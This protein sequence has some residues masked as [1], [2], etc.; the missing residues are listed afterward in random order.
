MSSI[1][2]TPSNYVKFALPKGRFMSST[3][4]LLQNVGLGFKD[5]FDKSRQYRLRSELSPY[6]SAKVFQ[7]KDI[8]VQVAIGNYDL[9][10][11]GLDWIEELT[12]RYP[13]SALIKI[14]NL[15]YGKGSIYLSASYQTGVFESDDLQ[16]KQYS[17][18][19]VSEYPNLAQAFALDRRL[20]KFK[21]F[22][23][24]GASEAYPPENADLAIL[25]AKNKK[26]LENYGLIP[27]EELVSSAAY[28]IGNRVSLENKKL[29]TILKCFGGIFFYKSKKTSPEKWKIEKPVISLPDWQMKSIKLALPDGHQQ[30]PTADLLKQAGVDIKGYNDII[31][32]RPYTDFDW[33]GLKVIRPQDMPLQIANGNFDL[34]ITGLD[35]LTEHLQ[36]YPASPA[37]KLLDLKFGKVKIVAAVSQTMPINSMADLKLYVNNN[38]PLRVASEYVNIADK[39]LRENHIQPYKLIPTWGASEAFIPED[40]DLLIDNAQ[41]GKTLE[42]HKLKIIDVLFE[43]AACLIGNRDIL[44]LPEKKDKVKFLMELLVRGL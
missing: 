4:T 15:G 31:M 3:A 8:P 41:T 20:R 25:W 27:L 6:I 28:L 12:A 16:A 24:W 43:S 18:S 29:D 19:I 37:V 14:A 32:T 23:V 2:E 36:R 39:Y 13:A 38:N 1:S 22:P 35:W 42:K 21:I 33:L 7:E 17:W 10:I 11:C 40:A 26:N 9:G 44:N 5:Y 34:A 30:K